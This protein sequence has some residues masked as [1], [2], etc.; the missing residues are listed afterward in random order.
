MTKK[1]E[2]SK[3]GGKGYLW[4]MP[5]DKLEADLLAKILGD[6]ILPFTGTMTVG[7]FQNFSVKIQ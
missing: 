6:T 5:T 2:L 3:K 7:I 4:N 1:K